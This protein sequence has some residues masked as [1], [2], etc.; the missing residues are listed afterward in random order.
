MLLQFP[1][2][3][4]T[5][6][7]SAP[8][9]RP[10]T[11]KVYQA[12]ITHPNTVVRFTSTE[13]FKPNDTFI[14]SSKAFFKKVIYRDQG[15]RITGEDLFNALKEAEK[16]TVKPAT[17]GF[18]SPLFRLIKALSGGRNPKQNDKIQAFT[19]EEDVIKNLPL[20][21]NART[22]RQNTEI[23]WN[24]Q[25]AL[26]EM[27]ELG[28]VEYI[29]E[30]YEKY[31]FLNRS[32]KEAYRLFRPQGAT[33]VETDILGIKDRLESQ[34]QAIK[35][36]ED[37]FE[38]ECIAIQ[39]EIDSETQKLEALQT[40]LSGSN[41]S[42]PLQNPLVLQADLKHQ[43]V[44]IK[45]LKM[46]LKVAQ[47]LREQYR[48]DAIQ[49]V[50]TVKTGLNSLALM[51]IR[52]ETLQLSG[53]LKEKKEMD[54]QLAIQLAEV[55][56]AANALQSALDTENPEAFV[57]LLRQVRQLESTQTE[58]DTSLKVTSSPLMERLQS[59]ALQSAATSASS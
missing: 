29:Y 27:K 32:G 19:T 36:K 18:F 49:A 33:G 42:S 6:P 56:V 13:D 10:Q 28:M 24:V 39:G 26:D 38:Q 2:S 50:L 9:S 22:E 46:K 21:Y 40:N 47:E 17:S 14:Q 51:T 5:R 4:S 25:S 59:P 45:A 37:H 53:Q 31:Y 52:A 30:N 41:A 16:N 55:Q 48:T 43:E 12:A 44:I 54:E 23:R 57:E 8:C 7:L 58:A 34:M 11:S 1:M 35:Q 3:Y 20:R 15:E